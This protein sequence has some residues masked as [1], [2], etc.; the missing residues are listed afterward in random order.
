MATERVRAKSSILSFPAEPEAVEW[1][2][3]LDC[4]RRM[5]VDEYLAEMARVAEE[6][7]AEVWLRWREDV[8]IEDWKEFVFSAVTK[9][10][11]DDRLSA[12]LGAVYGLTSAQ[13][14]RSK[15]GS[16]RTSSTRCLRH[17]PSVC[18]NPLEFLD[19]A[20]WLAGRDTEA[21]CSY[22]AVFLYIR[23]TV[24]PRFGEPARGT[25]VHRDLRLALGR[26]APNVAGDLDSLRQR[27][28]VADYDMTVS[29]SAESAAEA[30]ELADQILARLENHPL[31]PG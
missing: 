30:L 10:G 16:T 20:R 11:L 12:E 28:N 24:W 29:V 18:L 3:S 8:E 4:G 26:A 5:L 15:S 1:Y 27:R 23:D 2:E 25:R 19:A 13:P 21:L 14:V 22:Y 9:G 6:H 7:G 31:L 17:R